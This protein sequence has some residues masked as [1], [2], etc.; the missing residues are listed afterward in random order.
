VKAPRSER[1][2]STKHVQWPLLLLVFLVPQISS[3]Q[4]RIH[5]VLYD[6]AGTDSDNVFTEIV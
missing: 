3:S 6:G 2:S 1:Q 5:E 4:L